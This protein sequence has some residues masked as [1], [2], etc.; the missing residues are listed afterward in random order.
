MATP[1]RRHPRH[2]PAIAQNYDDSLAGTSLLAVDQ[3]FAEAYFDRPGRL[4][5]LGCGTGRLL[6][7]FARR[8]YSVLGTD[9]SEEMLKKTGE[10]AVAAGVII[11]RVK[12]NLVELDGLADRSFDYAACL[13]ST[14]GMVAGRAERRRVVDH[15]YRLLRPGG[16]FVVHVHNRWFNVWNRQG[17]VWLVRDGV[18]SLLRR[19]E[20]GDRVM[21]VHQGVAGLL[22]HVF[23]RGEAR[24]LL[25]LAG[26][27][28]LEIRPV[29]LAPDG[30]LPHDWFF[31]WLR[32]YGYLLAA[33]RPD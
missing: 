13:F 18:R 19:A 16:R 12:A 30:R 22:L 3:Q 27:R 24:R 7:P 2:D 29:S 15:A 10:K 5:D 32:A 8:G 1:A 11:H 21:P 17:R 4:I 20:E 25:E 26:F 23:S 28:I 14:L 9:L 31:G 6:I 33:E